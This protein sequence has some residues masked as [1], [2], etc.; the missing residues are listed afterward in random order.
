[1]IFF[2]VVGFVLFLLFLFV[3]EAYVSVQGSSRCT[4]GGTRETVYTG[5]PVCTASS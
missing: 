1:L 4:A 3:V 5:Y 2:V